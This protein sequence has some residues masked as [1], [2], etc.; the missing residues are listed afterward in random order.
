MQQAAESPS[1][2]WAVSSGVLDWLCELEQMS[3]RDRTPKHRRVLEEAT[4][5]LLAV[6]QP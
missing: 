2:G 6:Y 3:D 1:A 5:R 4:D